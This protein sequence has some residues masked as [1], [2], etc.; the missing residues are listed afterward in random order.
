MPSFSFLELEKNYHGNV[1]S[2][3]NQSGNVSTS[4]NQSGSVPEGKNYRETMMHITIMSN[5]LQSW[6]IEQS[7]KQVELCRNNYL[8]VCDPP[9]LPNVNTSL[10]FIVLELLS[11]E[12]RT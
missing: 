8:R 11:N 5:A 4:T 10:N 6:T 9:V 1:P 3:K 7:R 12:E 2:D